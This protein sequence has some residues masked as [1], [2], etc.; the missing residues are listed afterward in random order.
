VEPQLESEYK[1]EKLSGG[2]NEEE[3]RLKFERIDENETH[4]LPTIYLKDKPTIIEKEV[5]YNKPIEIK[6][7]IIHKEKPIIIEQPIIKEKYKQYTEE[8]KLEQEKQETIKE[9]IHERDDDNLDQQALENLREQRKQEFMDTRPNFEYR[10]E[11][12]QLDTDYREQPTEINEKEVVYQ[13]PIEIEKTT[14]E[15]VKPTIHKDVTVKKEH[16]YQ[17]VAPEFQQDNV[18]YIKENQQEMRQQ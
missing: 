17:K 12:I 9:S 2:L 3:N 6:E 16:V 10:K 18:Q 13:Q 15:Q 11:Y 14:I 4:I 1:E 5:E 7:T 8:T